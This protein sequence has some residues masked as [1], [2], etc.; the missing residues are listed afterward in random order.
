MSTQVEGSRPMYPK[1]RYSIAESLTLLGVSRK[2]FYSRVRAG[3]YQIVK[4]GSRSFMT[5]E[6]LIAAAAGDRR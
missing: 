2:H 3:R 1:P 6:A 5:H 4:D